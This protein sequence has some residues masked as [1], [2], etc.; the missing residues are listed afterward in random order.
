MKYQELADNVDKFEE[1]YELIECIYFGAIEKLG[2]A[3]NDLNKLD[4]IKHIR[5]VVRLFLINW[6]SMIRVVGREGTKW[7]QLSETLRGLE[8]EF[9]ELRGKKLLTI[10]LNDPIIAGAVKTIYSRLDPIPYLGSGTT[11]S[12]I[13]HL[14]NPEIFIMWDNAIVEKFH[15][16]NHCINYTSEGYLEFL[17]VAQKEIKEALDE[18]QIETGK[19]I[20]EIEQAIRFRYKNKTLAKIIDEYNWMTARH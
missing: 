2:E 7:K 5:R 12:K 8:N 18:R 16:M 3:Q 4:D 19:S 14:L 13:L 17:K 15:R 10:N 9:K 1:E 11:I 6:G 20:D